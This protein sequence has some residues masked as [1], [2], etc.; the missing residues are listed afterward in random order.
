MKQQILALP[1]KYKVLEK[2]DNVVKTIKLM[3]SLVHDT[4]GVKYPY[5]LA[6]EALLKVGN[7]RP[8]K[9]EARAEFHERWTEAW[10][11][12]AEQW[13]ELTVGDKIKGSDD[14]GVA[15]SKL[16][17]CMFLYRVGDQELLKEL[18]NQCVNKVDN[19]PK[20]VEG[21]MT[22]LS[23]RASQPSNNKSNSPSG[24][25]DGRTGKAF[26]MIKDRNCYNCGKKG[27]LK[28][29]CPELR[30]DNDSRSSSSRRSVNWNGLQLG[31]RSAFSCSRI[32]WMGRSLSDDED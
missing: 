4:E 28:K 21:V 12:F 8:Q 31:A 11:V 27:H 5:L 16:K 22:L 13:G 29:D 10:D 17:A 18:K 2:D 9:G 23:N 25:G 19:Y 24:R 6:W 1:D 3:K 15:L 20:S 30:S 32:S 7:M 26:V 14:N